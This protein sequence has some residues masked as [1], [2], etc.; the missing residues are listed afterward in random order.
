MAEVIDLEDV[1]RGINDMRQGYLRNKDKPGVEGVVAR[2][3]L[4]TD[5]GMTLWRAQEF[6]LGTD[7]NDVITAIIAAFSAALYGEISQLTADHGEQIDIA[8]NCTA[9]FAQALA[10]AILGQLPAN[11]YLSK[12]G[13]RA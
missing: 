5:Q 10:G 8:Q 4:A 1:M 9:G 11:T 3:G 2:C 7:P 13:G 6:N 12:E